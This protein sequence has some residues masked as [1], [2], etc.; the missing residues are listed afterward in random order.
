[1]GKE[2]FQQVWDDDYERLIGQSFVSKTVEDG[3]VYYKPQYA[4]LGNAWWW[5][6]CKAREDFLVSP[7]AALCKSPAHSKPYVQR[8]YSQDWIRTGHFKTLSQLHQETYDKTEFE[9]VMGLK[10]HTDSN[11]GYLYHTYSGGIEFLG[12]NK[13]PKNLKD[14]ITRIVAEGMVELSKHGIDYNDPL[15]SNLRYNFD[16]RLIC[17]PHNCM[18][19]HNKELSIKK[20]IKNLSYLLY[21]N[22]WIENHEEFLNEYFNE[23]VALLQ[24]SFYATLRFLW[25]LWLL[26][27]LL[28]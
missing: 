18:E 6:A 9:E 4:F 17:N 26:F 2:Y 22:F 7:Y 28:R 23:T 5:N 10:L 13:F 14:E 19:I 24:S 3:I 20:Q 8:E 21:T 1:M 11:L 12:I 16:G 27:D 25:V 15:P